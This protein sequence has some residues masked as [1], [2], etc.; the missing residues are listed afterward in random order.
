VEK[1]LVQSGEIY[2]YDI[3]NADSVPKN[4][5]DTMSLSYYE[6]EW[7]AAMNKEYLRFKDMQALA[8]VKQPK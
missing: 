7:E 3:N 4:Y 5:N 1:F 6:E 2:I 8:V